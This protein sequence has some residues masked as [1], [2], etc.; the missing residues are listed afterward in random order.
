MIKEFISSDSLWGLRSITNNCDL[1]VE[2]DKTQLPIRVVL[3]HSFELC[4]NGRLDALKTG[5]IG[6]SMVALKSLIRAV[7][8]LHQVA[9]KFLGNTITLDLVVASDWLGDAHT[10]AD[11][12]TENHRDISSLACTNFL[13]MD[14]GSGLKDVVYRRSFRSLFGLQLHRVLRQT[15]FTSPNL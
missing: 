11:V 3:L 4:V 2:R 14:L 12:N 5:N 1:I 8:E 6:H 15:E 9:L 10:T 7:G 13:V